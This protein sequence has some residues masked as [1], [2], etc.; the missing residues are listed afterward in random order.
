MPKTKF[1]INIISYDQDVLYE[2]GRIDFQRFRYGSP[3]EFLEDYNKKKGPFGIV[4]PTFFSFEFEKKDG[5]PYNMCD[6]LYERLE[7]WNQ[8]DYKFGVIIERFLCAQKNE[9]EKVIRFF[10]NFQTEYDD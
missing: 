6:Q 1:P 7:M 8:E 5:T 3:N 2:G 9:V 4:D 10:G